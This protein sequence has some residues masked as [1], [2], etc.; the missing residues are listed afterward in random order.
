MYYSI[1][2]NLSISNFLVW[3]QLKFVA[4]WV[5]DMRRHRFNIHY[6]YYI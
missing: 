6:I 2:I 1:T 4:D 5:D 3:F